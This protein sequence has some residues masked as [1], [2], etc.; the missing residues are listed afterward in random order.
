VR[1]LRQSVQQFQVSLNSDTRIKSNLLEDISNITTASRSVLLRMRNVSD[2]NCTESQNTH[3]MF[4]N[5]F[6]KPC[7][8]EINMGKYST[9]GQTRDE[10]IRVRLCKRSTCRKTTVKNT[11]TLSE[12]VILTALP[13][14]EW[15]YESASILHCAYIVC[16]ALF[17]V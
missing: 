10:K 3:F 1:L 5:Y 9:A 14:Q 12:S 6:F 8:Y 16:V 7:L 4:K 11:D 15:L 17:K 13:R 2:K